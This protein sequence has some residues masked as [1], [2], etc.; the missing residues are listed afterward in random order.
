MYKKIIITAIL[1]FIAF[2]PPKSKSDNDTP[3]ANTPTRT[4]ATQQTPEFRTVP[5]NLYNAN[6]NIRNAAQQ[7]S[8]PAA[9]SVNPASTNNI[10][11]IVIQGSRS[12]VRINS[13]PKVAI[14]ADH[15]SP[16]E[17]HFKTLIRSTSDAG[18][19]ISILLNNISIVDV[20]Y[21]SK[22][23]NTVLAEEIKQ[24]LSLVLSKS[25]SVTSLENTIKKLHILRTVNNTNT[26]FTPSNG[27]YTEQANISAYHQRVANFRQELINLK[28]NQWTTV[29]MEQMLN[30]IYHTTRSDATAQKIS[31]HDINGV[32]TD[33]E[34]RQ[35]LEYNIYLITM[36]KVC[37]CNLDTVQAAIDG[38]INLQKLNS[39]TTQH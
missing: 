14:Q 38:I 10:D 1:N 30:K 21:M 5:A 37:R 35:L 6:N 8:G 36:T 28:S 26:A 39:S 24:T 18:E 9:V 16:A 25:S 31:I 32:F 23:I 13:F 17:L 3:N 2:A 15:E 34:I 7:N 11:S 27:G 12:T 19:L 33:T 20:R 4:I 29:N 22:I